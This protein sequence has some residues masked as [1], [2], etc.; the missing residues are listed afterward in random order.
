M[1][2]GAGAPS[3]WTNY[4]ECRLYCRW[5]IRVGPVAGAANGAALTRDALPPNLRFSACPNTA[6]FGGGCKYTLNGTV[7]NNCPG[8]Y[9][10]HAMAN[11]WQKQDGSGETAGSNALL[12]RDKR[13]RAPMETAHQ[14]EDAN[15]T[16]DNQRLPSKQA[17]IRLGTPYAAA[18]FGGGSEAY[19]E[20]ACRKLGG[21]SVSMLGLYLPHARKIRVTIVV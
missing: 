10:E 2:G 17:M 15:Q 14:S 13:M 11:L 3:K 6:A 4:K 9:Y 19:R 20:R 5:E 1:S 18:D 12:T 21:D 8:T 16:H 7:I